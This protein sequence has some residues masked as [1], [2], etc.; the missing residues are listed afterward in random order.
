MNPTVRSH[1][2]QAKSVSPASFGSYGQPHREDGDNAARTPYGEVVSGWLGVLHPL[3]GYCRRR[4]SGAQFVS[5]G[6]T[7]CRRTNRASYEDLL[8]RALCM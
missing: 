3:S 1:R 5:H 6:A 8:F 2:Q 7:A 4:M